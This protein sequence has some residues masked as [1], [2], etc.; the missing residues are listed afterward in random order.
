MARDPTSSS[1][2]V[3][4]QP[5]VRTLPPRPKGEVGKVYDLVNQ[6]S[7]S[8]GW[9]AGI[10][11]AYLASLSTLDGDDL[12]GALRVAETWNKPVDGI[13]APAGADKIEATVVSMLQREAASE[14]G[15]YKGPAQLIL[16][17]AGD[18]NTPAG[19]YRAWG[20]LAGVLAATGAAGYVYV[21]WLK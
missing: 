21:R 1:S 6:V 7:A 8:K 4:P 12:P 2:G 10:R 15:A 16:P 14:S 3:A 18:V 11:L 13:P 5:T 20:I 9:P 19:R 17:G